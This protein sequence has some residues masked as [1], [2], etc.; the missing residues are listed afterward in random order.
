M[1]S[2]IAS[3]GRLEI[4]LLLISRK[5]RQADLQSA[6]GYQPALHLR[7]AALW[8]IY[9][10]W[11][12]MN[13]TT[14]MGSLGASGKCPSPSLIITVICPPSSLYLFSTTRVWSLS[15]GSRLPESCR[16]GMPA[17]ASG[18]RL[19]IGGDFAIRLRR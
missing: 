16:I 7:I 15:H 18:A 13:S 1:A 9:R 5:L 11:V 8:H 6:A 3:C 4:G 2:G 17:L 10:E 19:S 14:G 12:R